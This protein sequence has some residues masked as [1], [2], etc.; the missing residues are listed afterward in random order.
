MFLQT[1]IHESDPSHITVFCY[2]PN[3]LLLSDQQYYWGTENN[4]SHVTE[5]CLSLLLVTGL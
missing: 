4:I 3:I 2:Q 1:Y 5:K